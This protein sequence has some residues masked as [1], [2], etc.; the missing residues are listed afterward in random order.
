MGLPHIRWVSL[1]LDPVRAEIQPSEM[2]VNYVT[3]CSGSFFTAK[4]MLV[5]PYKKPWSLTRHSRMTNN[6]KPS[7]H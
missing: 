4:I 7:Y 6:I 3:N 1:L 5:Y 2:V